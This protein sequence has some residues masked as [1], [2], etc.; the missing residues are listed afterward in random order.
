MS[1]DNN[2]R[3]KDKRCPHCNSLLSPKTPESKFYDTIK[4]KDVYIVLT[5]DGI[6]LTAKLLWV[7]TYTLGLQDHNGVER[8]INKGSVETI[9]LLTSGTMRKRHVDHSGESSR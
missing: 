3:R 4:S 9:E 2:N 8:L 5:R 1:N 6:E 7:D